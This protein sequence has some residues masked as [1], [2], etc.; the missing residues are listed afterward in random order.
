MEIAH[1]GVGDGRVS[2]AQGVRP[3]AE[4]SSVAACPARGFCFSFLLSTWVIRKAP[5]SAGG[6]HSSGVEPLPKECE[7]LGSIPVV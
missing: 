4:P 2:G 1:T 6:M 3:R 5:P 7:A